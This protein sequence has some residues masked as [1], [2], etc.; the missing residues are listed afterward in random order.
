MEN[1]FEFTIM[2]KSSH[3]CGGADESNKALAACGLDAFLY[4]NIYSGMK[5]ILGK[6]IVKL[7][8]MPSHVGI[9]G[10]NISNGKKAPR[11]Y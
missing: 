5:K 10:F 11:V 4:E 1:V 7:V 9:F 3:K 8:S 6:I 2:N